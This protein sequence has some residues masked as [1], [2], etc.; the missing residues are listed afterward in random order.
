M[1]PRFNEIVVQWTSDHQWMSV[2]VTFLLW[3]WPWP[4]HLGTWPWP[5]Y[6]QD[7]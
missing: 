5:T 6:S 4:G 7:I 3:H 2:S 1:Q